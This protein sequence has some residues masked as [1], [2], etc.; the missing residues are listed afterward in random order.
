VRNAYLAFEYAESMNGRKLEDREV[1][2]WLHEY[3]IDTEK[4]DVGELTDYELPG[5]L[6][7][8]RRYLSTARKALGENKYT[9]RGGRKHG[10]SIVRSN[11]IEYQ[12]GDGR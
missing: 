4:G 11:Q 7:T 6:E 12:R 1:Y 2:E 9:R 5:S 10:G 3:G 8:F